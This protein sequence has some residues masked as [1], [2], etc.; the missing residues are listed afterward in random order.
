MKRKAGEIKRDL[1]NTNPRFLLTFSCF[2]FFLPRA[3]SPEAFVDSGCHVIFSVFLC[4]TLWILTAGVYV[5]VYDI[6][7]VKYPF[8]KFPLCRALAAGSAG[9]FFGRAIYCTLYMLHFVL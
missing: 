2:D 4:F 8:K 9:F 6:T 5:C 7:G 1:S 3:F